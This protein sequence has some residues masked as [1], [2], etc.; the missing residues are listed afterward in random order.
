M[1]QCHDFS[2]EFWAPGT[3]RL[4]DFIRVWLSV[5]TAD[6]LRQT[7]GQKKK[8]KAHILSQNVTAG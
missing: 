8:K 3:Y 1:L 2:N 7:N 4:P 6:V 5:Q